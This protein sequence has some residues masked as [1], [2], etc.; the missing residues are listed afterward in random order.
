MSQ[1]IKKN[2]R[3]ASRHITVLD[4][5]LAY[6]DLRQKLTK[7]GVFERDYAFYIPFILFVFVGFF[8]SIYALY[9]LQSYPLLILAGLVFTFFSVQIAGLLHDAGHR[10]IFKSTKN[11]DI[12][13][14]IC[15]IVLAMA[16]SSWKIKHN[17][18][19][20]HPNQ[21]GEDPD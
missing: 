9:V 16:Y 18:H 11:N 21:E 14:H 20:A 15:G 19:H 12:F 13:G 6:A 8:L 4:G 5:T 17:K 2:S 7:Q 1:T 3:K 10:A